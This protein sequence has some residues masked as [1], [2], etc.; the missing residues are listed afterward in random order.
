MSTSSNLFSWS[1]ASSIRL[2]EVDL[3]SAAL[4]LEPV[5]VPGEQPDR[6]HGAQVDVS[7]AAVRLEP[8][9]DP[10]LEVGRQQEM[11]PDCEENHDSRDDSGQKSNP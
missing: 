7:A 8:L 10:I 9:L 1:N 11:G 3:E 2:V 4:D 5:T 6:G